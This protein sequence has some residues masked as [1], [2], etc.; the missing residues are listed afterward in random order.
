MINSEA[1][2]TTA[3]HNASDEVA[4]DV[5]NPSPRTCSRFS[6]VIEAVLIFKDEDC[7]L[8]P[9][10]EEGKPIGVVTDRDVAL[11]LA[12]YNDL[13]DH[14]I[15]EIM[16]TITHLC[17][18]L[19]SCCRGGRDLRSGSSP[20]APGRR[21]WGPSRRCDRVEGCLWRD[22][23]SGGRPRRD[24]RRRKPDTILERSDDP[25]RPCESKPTRSG[26]RWRRS[27]LSSMKT[28]ARW[29]MSRRSPPTGGLTFEAIP[30]WRS[31]LPSPRDI[32]LYPVVRG[33]Q[34]LSSS[35]KGLTCGISR[36]PRRLRSRGD[37]HWC[38]GSSGRSV[39][40]HYEPP[41]RMR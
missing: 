24:G 19:N 22:L 5:M 1:P 17:L 37:C 20:T 3:V 31:A 12:T 16:S 13:V 29:S 23:R 36:R 18:T 26:A 32:S 34:R 33:P 21:R 27:G 9:V 35:R 28:C 15:E 14:P 25:W 11:A 4:A 38:A 2:G 10:V 6:Q 30:G 7:G 40:S 39:R 41:S 8:V